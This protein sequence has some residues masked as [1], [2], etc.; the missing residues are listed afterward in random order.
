MIFSPTFSLSVPS[1][2]PSF[3]S[4]ITRLLYKTH[5]MDVGNL[6]IYN[7]KPEQAQQPQT[8]SRYLPTQTNQPPATKNAWDEIGDYD[9]EPYIGNDIDDDDDDNKKEEPEAVAKTP[10]KK[11]KQE[12]DDAASIASQAAVKES[13]KNQLQK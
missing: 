5:K 12:S 11:E 8:K 10:T 7:K 13:Q 1:F 2:F 4:F 6:S 9:E 3:F